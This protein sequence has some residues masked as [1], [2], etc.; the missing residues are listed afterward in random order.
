M[1]GYEMMDAARQEAAQADRKAAEAWRFRYLKS[2]E[3]QLL[4]AVVSAAAKF[5]REAYDAL[6]A[7]RGARPAREQPVY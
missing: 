2:K 1:Y 5:L 4:E 7:H 6:R 3:R